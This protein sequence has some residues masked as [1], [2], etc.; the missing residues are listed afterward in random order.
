[1][2]GAT[3]E[4]VGK[5]WGWGWVLNSTTLFG[6]LHS[7]TLCTSLSRMWLHALVW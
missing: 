6:R 2:P 3:R 1:M 5:G 7:L 4:V